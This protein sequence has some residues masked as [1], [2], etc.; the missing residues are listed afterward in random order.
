MS[1]SRL[2]AAAESAFE[3]KAIPVRI[4]TISAGGGRVNQLG[5]QLEIDPKRTFFSSADG[6]KAASL[7]VIVFLSTKER[8]LAERRQRLAGR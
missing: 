2:R 3:Y 5:V 7:D 1:D 4:S 8:L 6:R